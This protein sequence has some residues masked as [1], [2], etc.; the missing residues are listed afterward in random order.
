M[1]HTV[2]KSPRE[3]IANCRPFFSSIRG[4][5]FLLLLSVLIPVM[6]V[7]I[8]YVYVRFQ[9]RVKSQLS[10]NLEVSRAVAATFKGFVT[11][12][13]HQEL[14]IGANLTTHEPLS[15]VEMNRILEL[16]KEEFPAVHSFIW[17][18]P[19]G[20]VISSSLAPAV[21][22][23]LTDRDYVHK[24]LSGKEWVVSGLIP[25]RFTGEPIF[26]VSRAIRGGNG[27]LLGAVV[28]AIQPEKLEG[29]ISIRLSKDE[30]ITIIDSEGKAVYREPKREWKWEDRK[31]LKGR[32]A[33]R[34]ALEGKEVI[35]V[36]PCC[37]SGE[38][39][40]VAIVPISSI[41]WA[42]SVGRSKGAV[43]APIISR[44][45]HGVVMF[46]LIM[47]AVFL[48]AFILSEGIS[49]SVRRLL[50]H[51]LALGGGER[52]EP[53]EESG[54]A[55]LKGL[56]SAFN[57]MA[58][59]VGAREKALKDAQ[60]RLI[61][62]CEAIP[63]CV[64]I[65]APDY[66]IR[67]A[68]RTFRETFGD[69][70]VKRCYELLAGRRQACE[71]CD[72]LCTVNTQTPRQWEWTDAHGKCFSIH[73]HPFTDSD[74]SP[75]VLKL[76]VDISE[77][78]LAW[79]AFLKSEK[80]YRE[81]VQNA[82][83]AIIRF[84][85]DGAITFFNEY[86]QA[87]FGYREDEV[88]GKPL[89]LL[90]PDRESDGVDLT[91]LA[92]DVVSCP[93]RY[94]NNVNENIRRDGS[95]VWM[96]WTNKPIPDESG[97]VAEILSVGIDITDRKQAEDLLRKS[98]QEKAGILGSLRNVAV[99]YL[100]PEMRVV[101][102]NSATEQVFSLAPEQLHGKKCYEAHGASKPCVGCPVACTLR[103]GEPEECEMAKEDGRVFLI[104]SNPVKDSSG[105]VTNVVKASMDITAR[106]Q[107]EEELRDEIS[108]RKQ[109]EARLRL[110]E[111]RL[112]ALWQLSQMSESSGDQ[113]AEFALEQLVGLTGSQ[114][115]WIGFLDEA[116]TVL[117]F[118]VWPKRH[119]GSE[120][121]LKIPVVRADIFGDA[122]RER[123]V[124][125]VNDFKGVV[126]EDF[127]E[128]QAGVSR[129]LV[130][131]VSERDRVVAIA[132]VGNKATEYDFSDA[133]ELTLLM[134]GMWKIIQREKAEKHLRASESLAAMGR[135]MAAVAHDMKTPLIAIGGFSRLAQKRIEDDS[136]VQDLLEIVVKETGRMES[137]VK[138]MLDFS[139]PLELEFSA[140]DIG[141]L[142]AEC[143]TI[144]EPLAQ[145]KGIKLNSRIEAGSLPSAWVD[146]RR[147][148]QALINILTNA[149]E[150]SPGGEEVMVGCCASGDNLVVSVVDCGCGIPQ[151]NRGEIFSPFY[152][153]KKD[154]TGLG[155]PIVK[156]IIDAHCGHIE[157]LDN[158]D[159]G[160]TFR[161]EIPIRRVN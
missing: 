96:A 59:K 50:E 5:H 79:Q 52:N 122:I 86:A 27:N 44:L 13:L 104:F 9:E 158:L 116:E 128:T 121:V 40:I 12:V 70:D 11:D 110:D 10:A 22:L 1:K 34:Q 63:A 148:K 55:E 151:G 75:L 136:P 46:L 35:G 160:I 145:E 147:M 123:R 77:R 20:R 17:L 93:E 39:R 97:K 81:L 161:V 89:G 125:V 15:A 134:D 138:D 157:I 49:S 61:S 92:R 19:H 16:N 132:G 105:K 140:A 155:L 113:I 129:I 71:N 66:S 99:E 18:G 72:L 36:F 120:P 152:T 74:G 91:T 62:V 76:A 37:N 30:A 47:A 149:I 88:I 111:A 118:H 153:S 73:T 143:L 21:G 146:C 100:D 31:L 94:V 3:N 4:R 14:A 43:M 117:T 127:L 54:P 103:T 58:E 119:A 109:V 106:K 29:L 51:T 80:R 82:N 67:Y 107:M 135:A 114:V 139:R 133:R 24:L 23:D 7:Q 38:K 25:S 124:V 6:L 141:R 2:L 83:S 64:Y 41:G 90:L 68:N 33:I 131:P 98:E 85:S 65:Q 60:E 84:N 56:A 87:F 115:G 112:E 159:K 126:L 32:K 69:P 78:K 28:A 130:V 53:I 154:G 95:R 144:V 137:M 101:W 156:K 142:V 57:V 48:G 150:A 45:L 102:A 26:T 108:E 42:A 8:G